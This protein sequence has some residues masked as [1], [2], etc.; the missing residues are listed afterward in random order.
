MRNLHLIYGARAEQVN[1]QRLN[2]VHQL[3]D[4]ESRAQNYTEF[5]PPDNRRALEL[6]SCIA[7]VLS[8]LG[9]MNLFG[10]AGDRR[11][12]CVHQLKEL[13]KS[14]FGGGGSGGGDDDADGGESASGKKS[15]KALLDKFCQSLEGALTQSPHVLIFTA[16]EDQD[17]GVTVNTKSPLFALIKKSGA[18]QYLKTQPYVFDFEDAIM[19]RDIGRLI[20]IFREWYRPDDDI[21]RRIFNTLLKTVRLLLQVRIWMDLLDSDM[22]EAR[23][24]EEFFPKGLMPNLMGEHPFRKDKLI[25]GGQHYTKDELIAAHER[26]LALNKLLY[27]TQRDL[28]VADFQ[29]AIELYLSQFCA[30][31]FTPAGR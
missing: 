4:A 22:D 10:A 12:I 25:Q 5:T 31:A 29:L 3:L 13:M 18:V 17:K 19:R 23:I 14:G 27:P 24:Q 2:L 21:K 9:T 6:K 1:E 15:G 16:V 11:V 20:G 30:G 26:L 8:E 28:Y 7:E